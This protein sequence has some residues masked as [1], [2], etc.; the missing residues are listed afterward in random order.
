M[1]DKLHI[2]ISIVAG[3]VYTTYCL[4]NNITLLFWMKHFIII[5]VLFYI[6]GLLT[7]NYLKNILINNYLKNDK[8]DVY[9]SEFLE[10]SELED[11]SDKKTPDSNEQKPRKKIDFDKDDN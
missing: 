4:I 8:E 11:F 9:S 3:I 7:R 1:L 2:F 5:V 6:L 10:D